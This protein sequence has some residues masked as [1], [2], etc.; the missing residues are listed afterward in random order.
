MKEAK[1]N[2]VRYKIRIPDSA[3]VVIE[4][5]RGE[6]PISTYLTEI[7]CKHAKEQEKATKQ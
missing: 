5:E 6:M 3:L 7:V 2:S 4:Q 1:Y